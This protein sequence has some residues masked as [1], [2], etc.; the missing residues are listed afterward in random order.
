MLGGIGNSMSC[1]ENVE[2]TCKSY[3][4]CYGCNSFRN[5]TNKE[6]ESFRVEKVKEKLPLET[7]YAV[8]SLKPNT[9]VINCEKII[10]A[11]KSVGIEIEATRNIL[12]KADTIIV[13]GI[14]FVKKVDKVEI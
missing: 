4:K 9:I 14:E 12:D 7:L 13:N 8:G 2:N 10:I 6:N 11:Q 1:I 5:P 3:P